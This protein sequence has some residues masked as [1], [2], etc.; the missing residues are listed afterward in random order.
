MGALE[1]WPSSSLAHASGV[2]AAPRIGPN[3]VL[4]T[5]RALVALEP[6]RV[7]AI[8]ARAI[9]PVALPPG[10]IPE[11]WFL[12]L[13]RAVRAELP[14][15]RAEAVLR[16]S[17][18]WTAAYVSTNRIP[19]PVRAA[20]R[21]LPSRVALSLMLHAI[22]Q[23]AWTFAGAGRF[24]VEGRYPF[25]IRLD[26]CPTCRPETAA[27]EG[28]SGA[29]YEAAFEG[30]LRLAAPRISVRE[31]ECRATGASTCRFRLSF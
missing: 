3:A 6:A 11:T 9:L 30:L 22:S 4:Q 29:W 12:Q 7:T 10:M 25:C 21:V 1:S 14:P 19:S 23:H 5:R 13:I 31:I 28:L 24:A 16:Q 8:E 26:D 17:G 18:A 15:E 27:H 20:M 2:I